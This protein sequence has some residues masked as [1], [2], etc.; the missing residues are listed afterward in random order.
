MFAAPD[1]AGLA[2][3][4]LYAELARQIAG[5]TAGEPDATANLANAAAVL[6]WGLTDV[7]WAGF[8]LW[9]GR[10]LVLGPFQGRPACIR[11]GLGRGVCGTAATE[12]RTL[13]VPDVDAFPG[14]IPCDGASRSEVVVPLL[15]A[16]RLLGVL[17]IDSPMIARFDQED[18]AGLERCVAAIVM[19]LDRAHATA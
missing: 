11:I 7:N 8:Y 2:K 4:E 10:E 19:A 6:F 1:T 16:G 18:A 17:D 9:D 12:R 15:A 14:H 3:P 5:L 13:V